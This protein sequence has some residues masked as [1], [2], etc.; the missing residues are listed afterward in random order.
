MAYPVP[1]AVVLTWPNAGTTWNIKIYPHIPIII[2][3]IITI[4]LSYR[5]LRAQ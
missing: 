2:N 5:N 4:M 1:V 3:I